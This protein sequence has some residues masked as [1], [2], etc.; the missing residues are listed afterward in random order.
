MGCH[1]IISWKLSKASH[2]SR[3]RR[4]YDMDGSGLRLSWPDESAIRRGV[5]SANFVYD[6]LQRLKPNLQL[7]D[8]W[9]ETDAAII[10]VASV[11]SAVPRIHVKEYAWHDDD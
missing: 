9:S 8:F 6:A 7:L 4:S 10:F 5:R 11:H 3:L 2:A 1:W